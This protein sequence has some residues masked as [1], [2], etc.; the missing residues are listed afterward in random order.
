MPD[1]NITVAHKVAVSDTTTIVCDNSDYMVHWTLD[2]EWSAYDTKTMRTIYMDGTFEDKVFS[3]DTIELPVCTV[4][5]AVQIGLFA[6]NIRA[7]RMAIL[8]ALPSVRSAA[9]APADPPESVYDQLMERMAQLETSDWAQNDPT[10]KDYVRNRTHYVSQENGVVV[11]EQE[12]TTAV[13]NNFNI[14]TLNDVDLDALTTLYGSEDDTTFDVVFDGASYP[15]KWL[16]QGGN[17]IPVFGNL[18]IHN[19]SVTDTGE[20]FCVTPGPKDTFVIECKVAGTHTVA[21]SYRQD[22][23]HTLDHKYIKDMYYS[24]IEEKNI[25]GVQIIGMT[26]DG[27]EH[28]PIPFRLG[29]V[30]NANF[31]EHN[32]WDDLEVKQSADGTLYIGDLNV[33]SIPFYVSVTSGGYNKQWMNM[34]HPGALTLTGV[35]GTMTETVVHTIPDKYIPTDIPRKRDLRE[36][37]PA[38][39]YNAHQDLSEDQKAQARQNIG[40]SANNNIDGFDDLAEKAPGSFGVWTGLQVGSA[41]SDMKSPALFIVGSGERGIYP[42]TIYDA[43][44]VVWTGANS[45]GT[46]SFDRK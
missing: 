21:V 22:V 39:Y 15:C 31:G 19:P 24:A 38:V 17:R 44:G 1:I 28:D 10:A 6:G 29:Q 43:N 30:W 18:A 40:A 23:V 16:K 34:M 5:G 4:P 35:S 11:P 13:Q 37:I 12:V 9:G 45:R 46:L 33:N 26:Y 27:T 20:P 36:L 7:S 32:N 3:G 25:A 8:R 41:P 14:A 2:D 42:I